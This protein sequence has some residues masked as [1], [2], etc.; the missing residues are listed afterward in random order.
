MVARISFS[1]KLSSVL[2][3]NEKKVAQNDAT[4]IHSSGF[5]NRT[6]RLSLQ[7]KMSR[8]SRLNELNTRSQVNMLH[9]S[10]NFDPSEH[11]SDGQ[12][13]NIA[14]RYME[15]L[16]LQNQPYLVYKH[17]DAGHPHIHLV[18]SLIKPD[19][20]R[21]RTHNMGKNLSEPTRKSIEKE[22]DLLPADS[23]QRKEAYIL[24]PLEV[25]KVVYGNTMQTK[26]AIRDVLMMV[27]KE[28]KFTSLP[29]YNAILR[30][31]NVLA[32]QGE[33]DSRTYQHGG[34]IYRVLDENGNKIGVP[35][36]ASDYFFKPTLTNLEK[37]FE[38][39]KELHQADL[40]KMRQ[41]IDWAL[42]Q[43]ARSLREFTTEL[44]KES[45]ELIIGQ[46]KTGPDYELTFVDN[47]LLSVARGSDL[48][49]AYSAES[50]LKGIATGQSRSLSP[51]QQYVQSQ[52]QA[53]PGNKS[54]QE[55]PLAA[56]HTFNFRIPQV[57]SQLMQSD[58]TFG[59]SPA[60]FEEDQDLR[61]RHRR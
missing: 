26:Q 11:L 43:G 48:G 10:L 28:Y 4:L 16:G 45:I 2:H 5:L 47:Q 6:E 51:G 25:Q 21:V 20:K 1:A 39:N 18:S 14:D 55:V 56:D 9:V 24:H 8:F 29:E 44:Q 15:G 31:Y 30:Q 52:D 38:L 59:N 19:G 42:Q 57:L 54:F 22:F 41:K 49:N 32:D 33:K 53:S 3:Y 34:L 40:P 12:L 7:E 27:G 37:K 61:P 58:P 13:S 36:K 35:V 60:E 50:I 46:N 17:T 23:H